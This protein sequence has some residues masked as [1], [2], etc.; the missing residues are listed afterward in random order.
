MG[1]GQGQAMLT[2]ALCAVLVCCLLCAVSLYL[3]MAWACLPQEPECVV[4]EGIRE[5]FL[6]E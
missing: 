6:Q 1:S 4:S 3:A 5:G 2:A